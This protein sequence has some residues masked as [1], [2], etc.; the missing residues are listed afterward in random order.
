MLAD[1]SVLVRDNVTTLDDGV[2][3]HTFTDPE[4]LRLFIHTWRGLRAQYPAVEFSL[5]SGGAI[6]TWVGA[7]TQPTPAQIATRV[8]AIRSAETQEGAEGE[9]LRGRVRTL[10]Q[11]AVGI[12]VDALTAPQVRALLIVLLYKRGAIDR[13]GAIRPF[14]EWE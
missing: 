5:D 1:L 13:T 12:Q 11:S 6:L 2:A 10:A 8:A 3:T 14:A 4:A 9:V 7:A